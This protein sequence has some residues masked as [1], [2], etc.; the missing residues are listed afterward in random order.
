MIGFFSRG[1]RRIQ[2]LGVLLD[3]TLVFRPQFQEGVDVI[4]GWGHKSTADKARRMAAEWGLPYLAV[5]DGFLRS[6]NLGVLGHPP[7][8][9]V[10]DDL[11][12]YY[13]ATGPSRLERILCE[14][15][16]SEA[17]LQLASIAIEA[18]VDGRLS[19]YNHAPDLEKGVLPKGDHQRILLIDQTRNDASVSLGMADS[20]TFVEMAAAA[21]REHPDADVLVK[22]HPDV[23]AG[24]KR[25]YLVDDDVAGTH[26]I[27]FDV[28]P[29]SLL[30]EVDHVYTVSSQMGFEALLAGCKV[31]CFGMPFYAGWGLTN[32]RLTLDR[33]GVNRSLVELFAAAYIRYARYVDPYSGKRCDI[34]AAIDNLVDQKRHND[35]NRGTFVCA[36]FSW[37]R[38]G[39]APHFFKS[40]EGEILFERTGRATADKARQSG[41]RA[42]VWSAKIP[43]RTL[44]VCAEE[45]VSVVG[46]EDGFLRSTGLGSD[47]YWPYSLCMD[48]RG[49][50]F[51]PSRPS[52]LEIILE[53][54]EFSERL[55][56]RARLLR[57]EIVGSGVTKYNVGQAESEVSFDSGGKPVVLVVGQ[58]END[59]SVELGGLGMSSD[60][61]LLQGVRDKRPDSYIIYKPH[62]DVVSGNRGGGA[63]AE[64]DK[65]YYDVMLTDVSLSSL[66]PVIDELHTLTSLSGF[67]ALLRGVPVHTY[68]GPFYAG[69]GLTDDR[70][71]FQRR[72]RR[73]Q[74]DKLVAG[75]LILYP[76]YYDW[77]TEMFCGP[78]VVLQR[79][80]NGEEPRQ[81]IVRQRVC[82][83]VQKVISVFK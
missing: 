36:G 42:L 18:V 51:D 56:K 50:Y 72:N 31:S 10:V 25:G 43:Q 77:T 23:M 44:K 16:Y 74:L 21:R 52:D 58:V 12:I 17:D 62:P 53:E 38:R 67:E 46:V 76:S 61:E 6:L 27:D 81:G 47:F 29:I 5:E 37:W 24:K 41:G 69:W 65:A 70:V 26:L 78:E 3:D 14:R 28:N 60:R 2:N 48:T 82:K 22:V 64:S 40:T 66:F 79:L 59:K 63:F 8:S 35:R 75:V 20:A 9:V 13:D 83:S 1:M 68:G 4:A 15:D 54:T 39:F 71:T 7:L 30:R 19:K 34:M 80:A 57:E 45:D 73:L 32:D 49:A 33:R 55:L 11:G